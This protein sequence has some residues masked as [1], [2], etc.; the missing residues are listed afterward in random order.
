MSIVLTLT[1]STFI[2]MF[3][4][5]RPDQFSGQAL[6]M[7]F[8][9]LDEGDTDVEFDPL[10]IC[11]EWAESSA[12]ELIDAYDIEVDTEADEDE[13]EQQVMDHMLYNTTVLGMTDAG[14]FV[15]VQ[16]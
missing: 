5:V 15:Y 7:I 14:H 10:A 13:R 1:R 12:E 2:N 11:C 3:R 4:E 16:F 8:D 6:R 9:Y